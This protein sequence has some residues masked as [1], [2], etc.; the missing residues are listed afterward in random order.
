MNK[1]LIDDY[2]LR[3]SKRIKALEFFLKEEDYADVVREA[4]EVVELMLKAL[5]LAA[6][7]DI[8]KTH[9]VSSFIKRHLEFFPKIVRCKYDDIRTIS[10]ELRKERE[11]SFYGAF[12][13]IPSEEYTIDDAERAIAHA[14]TIKE[15]V[16]QALKELM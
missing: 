3:A 16:E 7:L 1:R 11:L 10:R 5:I 12:D 4:Q 15:I 9:D 2:M 6:G 8:P 14:K 13:W